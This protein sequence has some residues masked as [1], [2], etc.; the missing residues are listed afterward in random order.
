MDGAECTFVGFAILQVSYGATVSRIGLLSS[1]WAYP[2]YCDSKTC[3]YYHSSYSITTKSFSA[4]Y[5]LHRNCVE[6]EVGEKSFYSYSFSPPTALTYVCVENVLGFQNLGSSTWTYSLP[7][8]ST[9]TIWQADR[10]D[11]NVRVNFSSMLQCFLAHDVL[12][13]EADVYQLM[14]PRQNISYSW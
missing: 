13:L 9:V 7:S 10:V 11:Q 4:L 1:M 3:F 14:E 5:R 8:I 6:F 12:H 2:D